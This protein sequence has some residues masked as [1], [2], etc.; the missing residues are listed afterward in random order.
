MTTRRL[1]MRRLTWALLPTRIMYTIE[2]CISAHRSNMID[3]RVLYPVKQHS[4]SRTSVVAQAL[5]HSLLSRR[6]ASFGGE[7]PVGRGTDGD[8]LWRWETG[9]RDV[10]L[11][12]SSID[13]ASRPIVSS[14]ADLSRDGY[15]WPSLHV[16]WPRSTEH[17]ALVAETRHAFLAFSRVA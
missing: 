4:S 10:P 13:A 15:A 8:N 14:A 5:G 1:Q 7:S 2:G 11:L 12:W 16:R 6:A 9:L 17:E 3:R